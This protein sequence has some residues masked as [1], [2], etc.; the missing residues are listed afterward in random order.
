MRLARRVSAAMNVSAPS[1]TIE[2]SGRPASIPAAENPGAKVAVMLCAMVVAEVSTQV[3][4]GRRWLARAVSSIAV[5]AQAGT[6]GL[7]W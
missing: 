2:T 1:R 6:A 5:T 7:T 3:P 4:K